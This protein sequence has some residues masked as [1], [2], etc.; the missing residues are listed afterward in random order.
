MAKIYPEKLPESILNDPMRSAECF[1][2]EK[3]AQL[4]AGFRVF[5]SV[6]WQSR[7]N[8]MTRDGEADFVIAHPEWGVL[9]LE[10]KGGRVDYDSQ[11]GTWTTTNRYDQVFSI[12]P[13]EQARKSHHTLLEKITDLPGWDSSRFLNIGHAVCFPTSVIKEKFLR[14]DMPREICI[15]NSDMGDIDAAI[16]R[17]FTYYFS[18]K[19]TEYGSLGND[20]LGIVEGLLAHSFKITTPLG[21][22]LDM[23]DRRLIELTEQQYRLLD[24]LGNRRRALIAGCAGSGKTMLAVEK[25]RKL[26]EQG[27]NVLLVCFNSALA[28]DLAQRLP[29][30][31]VL[32]FHGL[33]RELIKQAG[34]LLR[35]TANEKE[36]NDVI[37]PDGL[38]N[39]I[40]ET[41]QRFDAIIVDEG[42]DF[43]E[44][45]W[46]GLTG[47]LTEKEGIFYVF[48]DDNQNLYGGATTLS[49]II[50][51]PPFILTENCRNTQAIHKVVIDFRNNRESIGCHGPIG[52]IPE[53]LEYKDTSQMLRSLQSLLYRMTSE[54]SIRMENIVILT[55]H[56]KDN[57][58]LKPRVRLGNFSLTSNPPDKRNEIQATSIHRFKGLER[59]VVI[60]A[61]IDSQFTFNADMVMYVGCS[62]ARTHLIL[63]IEEGTSPGLKKKIE[64]LCIPT[65][66]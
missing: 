62:R 58:A 24:F 61:E 42:Q 50:D 13:V 14:L 15:D 25:A 34:L 56:G 54:E 20:R 53:F 23:E 3:L 35:P 66:S 48:Y 41:E 1:V 44:N 11:T 46:I 16:L 59:K 10:V 36:Y 47:L 7:K 32:H 40:D 38:I 17:V 52:R 6:A 9:V 2:F 65:G 49:G 8:G 19:Q 45:Y 55:P 64:D 51:E 63:L 26:A 29:N 12:D 5:Y 57:T 33:C 4:P 43:K 60:I 21:V 22:E 39:A 28:D 37:L 18:G 30:I 27:F 31:T